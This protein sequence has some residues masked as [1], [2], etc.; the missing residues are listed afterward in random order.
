MAVAACLLVSCG[1]K[2]PNLQTPVKKVKLEAVTLADS[3][4]EMSYPGL[5]SAT[6]EVNLAFRVAGQIAEIAVKEGDYVRAGQLIARMDTRDY[7]IQLQ[8]AQAQYDQV[9]AEAARVTELHNRQSVASNDYDKMVSGERMV[10]AQLKHAKDQ[11]NDTRLYAPAAGYI[12]KINFR[13]NELINTGMPLATLISTNQFQAEVDIPVSLFLMRDDILSYKATQPH[14]PNRV[15]ELKQLGFR[16]KANQNQLYRLQLAFGP[17]ARNVLAAGMD[18]QIHISCIKN[19]GE[20][21]FYVPLSALLHQNN[22]TFVWVYQPENQTVVSREVETGN[23]K[24][25]GKIRV[26][27]NVK[28]GDLVVSAGVSQLTENQNVEPIQ[29]VSQTNAGGLL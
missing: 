8:V 19:G 4:C 10:T 24:T 22:K 15:F 5:I 23:L 12:Q 28:A 18:V 27:G 7:E 26:V 6:D 1:N 21:G 9:K 2:A 13:V 29:P 17:E 16:K 20:A 3:V 25:D 11:L 14:L